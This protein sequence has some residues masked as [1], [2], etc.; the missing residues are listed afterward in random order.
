ETVPSV[1]RSSAGFLLSSPWLPPTAQWH[2]L[3]VG[4]AHAV[5]RQHNLP[6]RCPNSRAARVPTT[7]GQLGVS[8][9]CHGP[10]PT[11]KWRVASSGSLVQ[12]HHSTVRAPGFAML[13]STGTTG[14]T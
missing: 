11:A 13:K 7:T 2:E 10:T 9:S 12:P 6:S 1:R 5:R 3:A 4:Q 8:F 14:Y